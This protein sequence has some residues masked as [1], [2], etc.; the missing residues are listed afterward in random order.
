[1]YRVK[2]RIVH[3]EPIDLLLPVYLLLFTAVGYTT[4]GVS[5]ALVKA[6]ETIVA[7]LLYFGWVYFRD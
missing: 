2:R 4:G 6:A 1:M 3:A 5:G 7:F